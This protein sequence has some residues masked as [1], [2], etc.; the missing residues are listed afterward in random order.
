MICED[1]WD[2]DYLK[3]LHDI[4]TL[5]SIHASPYEINKIEKRIKVMHDINQMGIHTIYVNQVGGQD[6][7]VFDGQSMVF[8]KN[9][10]LIAKAKAFDEDLLTVSLHNNQWHGKKEPP[11]T[12]DQEI[13]EALKLGSSDFIKKNGLKKSV[14]GLSGGIDSAL[15]LAIAADSMGAKNVHAILMPSQYTAD[16]SIEDAIAQANA[17]GVSYEII[18]IEPIVEV[19]KKT[20]QNPASLTLQN[21]QARVRG[22]LLMAYSNQHQALLINT[23][24]KSETAVGYGTL[25]GDMCGGYAPL[26][27]IYKT[28]VYALAK[29]RNSLSPVIP[30]RVITRAPSA[31]LAPNQ[32]DEDD[33]PAYEILDELLIDVIENRL[34]EQQLQ[35]KFNAEMVSKILRKIKISE[36]KRYQSPPGCKVTPVAFGKDWRIPITH[37]WK[38]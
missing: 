36:F 18:P 34:T 27:D 12:P 17:L 13:Y 37:H 11:L 15:A 30:E 3:Q 8:D 24:N 23:S 19:F 2:K 28:K 1:I 38:I 32:K 10:E 16:A 5:V 25:Y 7:L 6:S 35:E 33:L 4:D 31:E 20:I 9:H 14:L 29:Y 22:V 21:L 26:Q